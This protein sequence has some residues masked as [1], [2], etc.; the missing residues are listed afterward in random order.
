MPSKVTG[1]MPSALDR[2]SLASFP[3]I[4]GFTIMRNDWSRA[5]A[6][7]EGNASLMSGRAEGLPDG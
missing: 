7:A 3:Q 6:S 1:R 5:P 4:S 2:R